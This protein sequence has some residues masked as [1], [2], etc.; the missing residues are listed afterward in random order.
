MSKSDPNEGAR[1][2]L[3]DPPELITK[4]KRAKTDPVMGLEFGNLSA[5]KPTTCLGSTPC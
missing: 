4:I 1:I 5:L 2:N 3:L